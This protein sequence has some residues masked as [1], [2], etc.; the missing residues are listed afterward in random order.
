MT[1]FQV[2][3][4]ALSFLL[5]LCMLAA[6][7]VWGFHAGTATLSRIFLGIGVPLLVATIWGIFLAP[8][9]T[10]RLRSL[11]RELLKLLIYG[12][13]VAALFTTGQPLLAL[14]FGLAVIINRLLVR[15][16]KQE[17]G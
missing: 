3:N 10:R 17:M 11:P 6:L 5:E 4:L 16:W 15:R 13:A 8:K 14:V 9:S 1:I 7:G 12:L 2:A